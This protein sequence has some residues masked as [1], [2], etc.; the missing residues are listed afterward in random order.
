MRLPLRRGVRPREV[1]GM[2][3]LLLGDSL[4][5]LLLFRGDGRY[6]V[7]TVRQG[8]ARSISVK[9]KIEKKT[10]YFHLSRRRRMP[11]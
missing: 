3:A 7:R 10:T 11:M 2:L 8:P 6:E 5:P 4:R 9:L 1:R